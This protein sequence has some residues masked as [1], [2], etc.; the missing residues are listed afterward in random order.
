MGRARG[1]EKDYGNIGYDFN[2]PDEFH[3]E[4][5]EDEKDSLGDIAFHCDRIGIKNIDQL[6]KSID[7]QFTSFL[8]RIYANNKWYVSDSF[9]LYILLIRA[10]IR[11]FTVED[12]VETGWG[13]S[14]AERVIRGAIEDAK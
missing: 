10:N 14:T 2:P 5:E 8:K 3:D 4:E 7:G 13:E 9:V 12:L 11:Q 1:V 6:L